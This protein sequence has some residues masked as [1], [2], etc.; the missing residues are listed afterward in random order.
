[1]NNLGHYYYTK[2][3]KEKAKKYFKMASDKG[4][5]CAMRNLSNI[6]KLENN[7]K[8]YVKYM[9]KVIA[10][11]DFSKVND[12]GLYF[13]NIQDYDNAEK[14]FKIGVDHGDIATMNNL[15][16]YYS[17]KNDN[18]KAMDY[19]TMAM[20]KGCADA[21]GN[22][23][24]L[25]E[26]YKKYDEMEKYYLMAIEHGCTFIQVINGIEH[27]YINNP[28]KLLRLYVKYE[29]LYKRYKTIQQFKKLMDL[30]LS[31]EDEKEYCELLITYKF[32]DDDKLS[33]GLKLLV[34][35]L[36]DKLTIYDLH[37]KYSIK[38]KGYDDAKNDFFDRA[39]KKIDNEKQIKT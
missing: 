39:C 18:E 28:I 24:V 17:I 29:N 11:G 5:I 36:T 30:S 33:T 20:E 10:N 6:Y 12:L 1:M 25:Y 16:H 4:R 19:F 14:Y 13:L 31:F 34:K 15:G 8:K 2:K 22:M 38:G 7:M 23:G 35:T 3:N 26:K 9:E 37:F 32:N 27:Y 21:M